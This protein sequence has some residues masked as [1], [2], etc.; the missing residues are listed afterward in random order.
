MDIVDVTNM[1]ADDYMTSRS[2]TSVLAKKYKG[3][4]VAVME[5]VQQKRL[6]G[7]YGIALQPKRKVSV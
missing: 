1:G 4:C 5:F 7:I 6:A 3:R 2:G